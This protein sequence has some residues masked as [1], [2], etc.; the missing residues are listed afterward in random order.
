VSRS[1]VVRALA[2]DDE[3]LEQDVADVLARVGVGGCEIRVRNGIVEL[4]GS[5]TVTRRP[6][7]STVVDAVAGMPGV[8]A[9]HVIASTAAPTTPPAARS[10]SA[11]SAS[12]KE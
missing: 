11:R 5:E 9:V 8:S 4:I 6:E 10:A 1:D 3:A 2:R 12:A 7:L